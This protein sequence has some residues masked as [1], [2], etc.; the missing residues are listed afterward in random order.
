MFNRE[1]H[2]ELAT[3]PSLSFHTGE[4]IKNRVEYFMKMYNR[5]G[6]VFAIHVG[7]GT[8]ARFVCLAR[9]LQHLLHQIHYH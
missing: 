6:V 4:R 2:E 7:L 9:L 5:E 8:C 1:I 3:R